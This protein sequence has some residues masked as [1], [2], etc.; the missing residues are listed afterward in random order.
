MVLG[1]CPTITAALGNKSESCCLLRYMRVLGRFL[2]PLPSSNSDI[3]VQVR[4]AESPLRLSEF[5]SN[6]SPPSYRACHDFLR[7]FSVSLFV[8]LQPCVLPP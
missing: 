3:L 6:L 4:T 1:H 8:I 7:C 2:L 5:Q